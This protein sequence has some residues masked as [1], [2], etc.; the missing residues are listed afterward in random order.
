MTASTI[1]T[2]PLIPDLLK[3]RD[4]VGVLSVY[5][6]VDP[7]AEAHPRSAWQIRVD[8]DL[9]AI[10]RRLCIKGAC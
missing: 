8:N 7:A 1:D 4:D 5:V 3:L 9:R 6:G 2:D 10:R